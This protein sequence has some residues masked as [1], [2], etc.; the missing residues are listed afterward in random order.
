[1]IAVLGK[2]ESV[3]VAIASASRYEN[4]RSALNG[5][6]SGELLTLSADQFRYDA[7]TRTLTWALDA[8]AGGTAP[9]AD[10]YYEW[11]VYGSLVTDTAGNKLNDGRMTT[12]P[13]HRLFGDLNGDGTVDT[14]DQARVNAAL[15]SRPGSVA[16][17]PDADLDGDGIVTA[18]DRKL[19]AQAIGKKVIYR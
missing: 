18:R 7:A 1:M 4:P 16:W 17:D 19:L 11:Q 14:A 2:E 6:G 8:V 10:G 12:R 13:F 15:G 3:A 5:K 9:L